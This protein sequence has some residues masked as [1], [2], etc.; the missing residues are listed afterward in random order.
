MI[1]LILGFKQTANTYLWN[2]QPHTTNTV[3][4][5]YFWGSMAPAVGKGGQKTG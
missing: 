3:P 1:D 5:L 4:D 2:S